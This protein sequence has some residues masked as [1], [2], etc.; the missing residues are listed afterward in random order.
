[1]RGRSRRIGDRAI[2]IALGVLLGLVVIVIF[3]FLGSRNTIDE[4][5]LSGGATTVTHAQP[6]APPAKVSQPKPS[7]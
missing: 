2:G 3:L 6:A 4:P 7:K 1:M 5:S